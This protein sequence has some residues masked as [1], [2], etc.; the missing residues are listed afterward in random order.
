MQSLKPR[1]PPRLCL[2]TGDADSDCTAHSDCS[3]LT[4][5]RL[6]PAE[7]DGEGGEGIYVL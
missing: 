7:D 3:A 6:H 4:G 2:S 1:R 5:Q